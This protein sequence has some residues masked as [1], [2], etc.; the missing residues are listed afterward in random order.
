[1][2]RRLELVQC[3]ETGGEGRLS[4]QPGPESVFDAFDPFQLDLA[5]EKPPL[6]LISRLRLLHICTHT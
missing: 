1:M 5:T 2:E 4:D 6:M 3:Q